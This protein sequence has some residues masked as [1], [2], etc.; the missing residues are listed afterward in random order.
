MV[1]LVHTWLVEADTTIFYGQKWKKYYLFTFI[2]LNNHLDRARVTLWMK[3]K[4]TILL[5]LQ[6][7]SFGPKKFRFHAW[8]KKCHFGN[9]TR[10][11]PIGWI[12]QALLVQPSISA[13]RKWPEMVVSAST[14]QLWPK[15]TIKIYPW[16]FAI[17]IPSSVK[18]ICK[19]LY[20]QY[21]KMYLLLF[22]SDTTI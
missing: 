8:V 5:T 12:G 14:N 6:M 11:R 2:N 7:K 3:F 18:R 10:N 17:Q 20:V 22:F 4:R 21:W 16:S 19:L 13:N 15:I 9:F 1:I